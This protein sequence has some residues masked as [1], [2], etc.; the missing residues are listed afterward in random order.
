MPHQEGPHPDYEVGYLILGIAPEESAISP[1]VL[2]F[3]SRENEVLSTCHRRARARFEHV[4]SGG[5][6][7]GNVHSGGIKYSQVFGERGLFAS[8]GDYQWSVVHI[9]DEILP[10]GG[11][12]KLLPSPVLFTEYLSWLRIMAM[13]MGDD[14]STVGRRRGRHVLL[15]S[16]EY[17]EM[18]EATCLESRQ[19]CDQDH[20]T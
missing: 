12:G 17:V 4:G 19:A 18:L 16:R 5:R 13:R 14:R 6:I 11:H 2:S 3:Y 7:R 10:G 20:I 8:R 9:L 1:V 15:L